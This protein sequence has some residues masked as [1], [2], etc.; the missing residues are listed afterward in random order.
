[1]LKQRTLRRGKIA[2]EITNPNLTALGW[3][4]LLWE[5]TVEFARGRARGDTRRQDELPPDGRALLA[6]LGDELRRLDE[7]V[8]RFDDRIEA[9]SR[10]DPASRRLGATLPAV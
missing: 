5:A 4:K 1:M 3:V 6:E 8:K 10:A 9:I 7:R 2:F